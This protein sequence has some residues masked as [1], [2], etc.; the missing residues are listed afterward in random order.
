MPPARPGNTNC[1]SCYGLGWTLDK[2]M[3][4]RCAPCDVYR[5]DAVAADAA[6]QTMQQLFLRLGPGE[7]LVSG[8]GYEPFVLQPLPEF[9]DT[10]ECGTELLAVE[11]G[12]DRYGEVSL[13]DQVLMIEQNDFSK[14][15]SGPHYLYCSGC[16]RAYALPEEVDF[17]FAHRTL[18]TWPTDILFPY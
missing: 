15:G 6:A 3:V 5:N 16:E 17:R 13:E 11:A 1:D 14:E 2:T 4:S 7:Q 18:G 9:S 10:C 8:H 12:Y